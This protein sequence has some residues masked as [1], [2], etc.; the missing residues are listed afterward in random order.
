MSQFNKMAEIGSFD[1][2]D[3]VQLRGSGNKLL[4]DRGYPSLFAPDSEDEFSSD[5]DS[6]K[7]EQTR[8]TLLPLEVRNCF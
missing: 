7:E 2:L 4:M 8:P 3:T 5:S 1:R 6:A